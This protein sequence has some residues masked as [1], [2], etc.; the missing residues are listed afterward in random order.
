MFEYSSDFLIEVTPI[1][2]AYGLIPGHIKDE[3]IVVGNHRDGE[4]SSEICTGCGLTLYDNSLGE[5]AERY[6]LN[7]IP[8]QLIGHGRN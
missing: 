8:E 3:V 4:C 6:L 7:I 1:W 2:N 5:D